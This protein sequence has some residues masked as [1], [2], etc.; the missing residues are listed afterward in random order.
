V[1]DITGIII[2]SYELKN[3]ESIIDLTGSSEGVYFLSIISDQKKYDQ[4]LIIC[5]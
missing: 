1:K 5:K 3:E 2:Y 4:R